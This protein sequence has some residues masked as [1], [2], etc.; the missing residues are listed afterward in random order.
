LYS[1]IETGCLGLWVCVHWRVHFDFSQDPLPSRVR[2][3]QLLLGLPV[4]VLRSDPS[5]A[6][7]F[8]LALLTMPGLGYACIKFASLFAAPTTV[9]VPSLLAATGAGTAAAVGARSGPGPAAVAGAGGAAAS[10]PSGAGHAFVLL[11]VQW[12][13]LVLELVRWKREMPLGRAIDAY[14][15]PAVGIQ[16]ALSVVPMFYPV[17]VFKNYCTV[18]WNCCSFCMAL[19]VPVIPVPVSNCQY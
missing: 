13:A 11:P 3:A 12:E 8:A 14:R 19:R 17:A 10:T 9:A 2:L 1:C 7:P 18:Q 6:L 4:A 15:P 5:A 16:G